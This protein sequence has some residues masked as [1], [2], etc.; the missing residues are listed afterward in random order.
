MSH[1]ES[2]R[3]P[4]DMP[5]FDSE[6]F[7]AQ[8]AGTVTPERQ[9]IVEQL[10]QRVWFQAT[11]PTLQEALTYLPDTGIE[12]HDG[13]LQDLANRPDE[14]SGVTVQK[15]VD[16]PRG[17]FALIPKFEVKNSND[18]SYTYEYVSWRQ[19][20]QSG[21]KGI[22]F[23]RPPLPGASPTHFVTLVGEKFA[24]GRKVNDSVGGFIDIGVDGVQNL[25]GRIDKEIR[26]ETGVEDLK[27]DEVV[28][29]GPMQVDAGMTNNRPNLFAAFIDT[30]QAGRIPD[31]PINS[32]IYELASGAL[33]LPMTHL[34]D[35]ILSNTDAFFQAAMLKAIAEGH[36]PYEWLAR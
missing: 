29:L 31:K 2:I 3:Q 22:V 11:D 5:A 30:E 9:K 18:Q 4:N 33:V 27:I 7:L 24:P 15:L 34:K 21:A 17:N 28:D 20:P 23:V 8:V 19:G 26:E 1:H 10:A 32:D 25:M 6:V 13:F 12:N 36:V 14:I 16:L 35:F